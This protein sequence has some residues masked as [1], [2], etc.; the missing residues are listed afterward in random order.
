MKARRLDVHLTHTDHTRRRVEALVKKL[1]AKFPG[2][3][4]TNVSVVQTAIEHGLGIMEREAA[5]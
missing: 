4:F 2:A 1:N 3:R 5:K